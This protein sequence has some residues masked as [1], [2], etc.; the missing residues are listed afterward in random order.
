MQ[1]SSEGD[2]EYNFVF[3]ETTLKLV[4]QSQASAAQEE[5]EESEEEEEEEDEEEEEEED[6]EDGEEEEEEEEE[7]VT[8][9]ETD[10]A[11]VSSKGECLHDL[12]GEQFWIKPLS[13]FECLWFVS[14]WDH[15]LKSV[16]LHSWQGGNRVPTRL[17]IIWPSS[18][19]VFPAR[20]FGFT[21]FW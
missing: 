9:T 19:L 17:S 16:F 13:D 12:V 1:K 4:Q 3:Q 20:S 8:S 14:V 11:P 6:K 10:S 18:S 5:E 21:I 15:V 2:R 7:E